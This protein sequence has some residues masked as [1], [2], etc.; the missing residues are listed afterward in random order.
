MLSFVVFLCLNLNPVSLNV[1]CK[2]Q[3]VVNRPT[4]KFIKILC[5]AVWLA[6]GKFS[7]KSCFIVYYFFILFP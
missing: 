1:K 2:N 3:A 7:E 6:L 5:N 4:S